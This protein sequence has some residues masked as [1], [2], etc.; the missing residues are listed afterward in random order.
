MHIITD[1]LW[2]IVSNFIPSKKSKVGRPE[3]D[4]RKTFE[5]IHHIL[6]EGGRWSSLE[7]VGYGKRSTI[8]GKFKKW[9]KDGVFK[10]IADSIVTYYR[11]TQKTN[12]NWYAIDSTSKAAPFLKTAGKN[13]TDRKKRGVKYVLAVDR[14]GAPIAIDIAP[15]NKHDSQLI[16]TILKDLSNMDIVQIVV[17]DSAFDS[18]KLRKKAADLNIALIASV[19]PRKDTSKRRTYIWHRWIVEQTFG[20]LMQNR[21]LKPCYFKLN[22]TLL[23]ILQL[24]CAIRIF[25]M[26]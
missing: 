16:D 19:N 24:A 1:S 13:P 18:K 20:I 26:L 9:C 11:S 2:S 23:G 25:S 10:R 4:V 12:Y 8:H 15:A 3:Y 6:R 22:S 14:K 7:K 5:A 17:G 21:G